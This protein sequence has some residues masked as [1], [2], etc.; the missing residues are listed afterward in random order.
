MKRSLNR[1]GKVNSLATEDYLKQ[2]NFSCHFQ[3]RLNA[4]RSSPREQ[5]ANLAVLKR[6]GR[7]ERCICYTAC[8]CIFLWGNWVWSQLRLSRPQSIG[9][10]ASFASQIN[11]CDCCTLSW[12]GSSQ[13]DDEAS[14]KNSLNAGTQL[15]S[16][17]EDE[18]AQN[19]LENRTFFTVCIGVT[20]SAH[21]VVQQCQRKTMN[22]F[23][24]S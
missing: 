21:T 23:N 11:T 24:Y 12:L 15:L 10:P 14:E 19:R 6:A 2:F 16:E 13:H 18:G 7:G 17:I 1:V 8:A 20:E 22:W 4:A 9:N 5:K 3:P